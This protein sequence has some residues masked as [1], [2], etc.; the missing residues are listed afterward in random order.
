MCLTGNRKEGSGRSVPLAPAPWLRL[1]YRYGVWGQGGGAAG[2]TGFLGLTLLI[3]WPGGSLASRL[4]AYV[5]FHLWPEL[6]FL[7]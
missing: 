2:E 3:S 7:R 4:I 6:H 5:W 1:L